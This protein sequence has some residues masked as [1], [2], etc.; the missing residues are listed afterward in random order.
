MYVIRLLFIVYLYSLFTCACS[1][2]N[3]LQSKSTSLHTNVGNQNKSANTSIA[4]D[5]LIT[6][7]NR[8][9]NAFGVNLA[10]QSRI[11]TTSY[12]EN[13]HAFDGNKMKDGNPDTYWSTDD[14]IKNASIVIDLIKAHQLNYLLLSEYPPLG[15]RISG[16]TLDAFIENRWKRIGEG[17]TIGK[18]K[19]I[20]FRSIYTAWIRI[21]ITNSSANPAISE[22]AVY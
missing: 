19:I 12:R 18:L 5:S 11:I 4:E 16:F 1:D 6:A 20:K 7:N 15:E 2:Q 10:E 9:I 3:S 21:N 13:S 14:S 8:I 22:I 17:T